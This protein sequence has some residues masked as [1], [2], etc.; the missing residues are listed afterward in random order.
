MPRGC[1][2]LLL[3]LWATQSLAAAFWVDRPTDPRV[4]DAS[5]FDLLYGACPGPN[6]SFHPM[7]GYRMPAD[8]PRVSMNIPVHKYPCFQAR[9]V[10]ADNRWYLTSAVIDLRGGQ[11]MPPILFVSL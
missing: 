9:A 11:P 7:G 8:R 5:A 1:L 2:A 6:E 3:A 4:A 10:G